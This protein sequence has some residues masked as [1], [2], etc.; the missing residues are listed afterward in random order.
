ME[1]ILEQW[2]GRQW[3]PGHSDDRVSTTLTLTLLVEILFLL[4]LLRSSTFPYFRLSLCLG[5]NPI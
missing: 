3:S 1:R 5:L 2:I 4:L